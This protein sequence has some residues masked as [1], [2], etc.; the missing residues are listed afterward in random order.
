MVT[1]SHCVCVSRR[2]TRPRAWSLRCGGCCERGPLPP[3]PSRKGRG[4]KNLTPPPFAGGGWGEGTAMTPL[5]AAQADL[6]A[7]EAIVRSAGTSFYR[8]MRVLPPDRRHAM[9]A[10][11]GFCCMVDDIADE[12]CAFGA[13]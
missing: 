10:I 3:T 8:G 5:N 4:R 2:A 12:E 9:Y 1:L 11:Y 6:D 13:K 7:V